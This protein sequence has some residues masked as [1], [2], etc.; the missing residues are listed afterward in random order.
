[1][2]LV[3]DVQG[4]DKIT[5]ICG[6]DAAETKVFNKSNTNCY[7]GFQ[8]IPVGRLWP[9]TINLEN[10]NFCEVKGNYFEFY[11]NMYAFNISN[12]EL[13]SL[14][15]GF[16]AA[17]N[18]TDLIIS[19]N[20]ITTIPGMVFEHA[21]QL[22][23]LD[24]SQ[25]FIEKI[26]TMSFYGAISL[27]SLDLSQNSIKRFH[28]QALNVLTNLRSLNF[29]QNSLSDFATFDLPN[30]LELDLSHNYVANISGKV[31][32]DLRQLE[33]LF[34]SYNPITDLKEDTFASLP[35]LKTLSLRGTNLA[36]IH[37]ETF[38]AQTM[39]V[40]LDLSHNY[41]TKLDFAVFRT[42]I[43][44]SLIVAN[45]QLQE[46]RHF[47]NERLPQFIL[48]DMR[49]NSFSCSYLDHF[50]DSIESKSIEIPADQSS[51]NLNIRGIECD[52]DR[53]PNR[54]NK[55]LKYQTLIMVI[56]FV[57]LTFVIL[58]IGVIF[59]W[60]RMTKSPTTITFTRTSTGMI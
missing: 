20:K 57:M 49:N 58:F 12:V 36:N 10:C 39:L 27:Q 38:A 13:K 29:S 35:K 54:S 1:M 28:V 4:L 59:Y 46:F 50:M 24:I 11:S 26:E 31:F 9:G 17:T 19:R 34:L 7:D 30:V 3:N 8:I 52:D 16:D 40:S 33:R 6:E 37:M 14:L 43:L 55:A 2:K 21:R 44:E 32:N 25:N 51:T 23:H 22:T 60:K 48:F 5:L 15:T 41:L 47:S 45:N 18:I 53:R 42:K 56:C